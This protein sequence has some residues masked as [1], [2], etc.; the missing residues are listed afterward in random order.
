MSS[1]SRNAIDPVI[2]QCRGNSRKTVGVV[3][4][5]MH[6]AERPPRGGPRPRPAHQGPA[7][8][9]LHILFL[10]RALGRCVRTLARA[11]K[12]YFKIEQ[13]TPINQAVLP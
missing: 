10:R 6:H 1:S 13:G 7:L 12:R 11:A 5:A 3:H 9:A 8:A 4:P 2:G